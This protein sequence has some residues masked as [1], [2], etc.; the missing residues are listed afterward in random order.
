MRKFALLALGAS[1]VCS[2]VSAAVT[3]AFD[4]INVRTESGGVPFGDF[5]LS[6]TFPD[7]VRAYLPITELPADQRPQATT[8]G[9]PVNFVGTVSGGRW[10]FATN[11][12]GF[13]L[14]NGG[15]GFG[16]GEAFVFDLLTPVSGFITMNGSF[17]GS[18]LGNS[19][20]VG[21]GVFVS[22][23][24]LTI[25]GEPD[26]VPSPAPATLALFGLGVAAAGLRLRRR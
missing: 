16:T 15:F 22:E 14:E 20:P 23:A 25:S 8:V 26:V 13:L 17:A 7:Y 9:Y 10:A 1:L 6:L 11:G 5:S 24:R 19:R 3:Y 12:T 18:V 21:R 2:P 4:F